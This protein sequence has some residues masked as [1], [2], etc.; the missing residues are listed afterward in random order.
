MYNYTID[1]MIYYNV[2]YIYIDNIH[3][4]CAHK[5]I[6]FSYIMYIYI[7]IWIVYYQLKCHFYEHVLFFSLLAM[8]DS[9]IFQAQGPPIYPGAGEN[10]LD[11]TGKWEIP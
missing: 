3:S 4:V 5:T 11:S 2:I 8:W 9:Q 10:G 7:Y 1:N 6:Y